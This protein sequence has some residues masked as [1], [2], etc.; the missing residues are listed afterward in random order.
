MIDRRCYPMIQADERLRFV[1]VTSLSTIRNSRLM[2]AYCR[3]HPREIQRNALIN[4]TFYAAR[5]KSKLKP[6][7]LARLA[8]SRSIR[9]LRAFQT[10]SQEHAGK[11]YIIVKDEQ[12]FRQSNLSDRSSMIALLSFCFFL[13]IFFFSVWKSEIVFR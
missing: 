3:V 9:L 2:H 13:F 7:I 8:P 10:S 12:I 1:L 4:Q 5:F 6:M 11:S